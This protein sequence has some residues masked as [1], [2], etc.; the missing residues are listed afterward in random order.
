M[1]RWCL[2]WVPLGSQMRYVFS[3]VCSKSLWCK[4]I[5]V[6]TGGDN[7]C[8]K[9][10]RGSLAN[11]SAILGKNAPSVISIWHITQLNI[12]TFDE[13]GC[14]QK[15]VGSVQTVSGNPP[16][17]LHDSWMENSFTASLAMRGICD[18]NSNSK[19]SPTK[20][21]WFVFIFQEYPIRTLYISIILIYI[22]IYIYILSTHRIHGKMVYLPTLCWFF[23]VFM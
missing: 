15:A 20:T 4:I 2:S 11:N 9:E 19:V 16:G 10:T 13:T 8:Y 6:L 3:L 18:L 14:F 22:Y 12:Y 17:L 7:E 23:M 1:R 21:W 5:R